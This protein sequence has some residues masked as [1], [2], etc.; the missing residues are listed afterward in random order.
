[1]ILPGIDE[2]A[3]AMCKAR[4]RTCACEINSREAC[5]TWRQIGAA[6]IDHI[7]W[8]NNEKPTESIT[9]RGVAA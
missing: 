1:M 4:Y 8:I 2:L 6:A 9:N 3:K 5:A 7:K